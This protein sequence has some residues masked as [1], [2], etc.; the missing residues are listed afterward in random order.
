[1]ISNTKEEILSLLASL[2]DDTVAITIH[3]VS[4][5][6]YE[7][8]YDD[9]M[10]CSKEHDNDK[11]FCSSKETYEINN[12]DITD[13]IDFDVNTVNTKCYVMAQVFDDSEQELI[14]DQEDINVMFPSLIDNQDVSNAFQPS[15]PSTIIALHILWFD[16][17]FSISNNNKSNESDKDD[18]SMFDTSDEDY[19]L[20]DDDSNKSNEVRWSTSSKVNNDKRTIIYISSNK[21]NEDYDQYIKILPSNKS[22]DRQNINYIVLDNNNNNMVI[23]LRQDAPTVC[24]II[25][26]DINSYANDNI[27]WY[28]Q[29]FTIYEK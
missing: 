28:I 12:K 26:S 21:S 16:H 20:H 8:L 4:Y 22:S 13:K 27:L 17:G 3:E 9:I 19:D 7:S 10:E 15:N 5:P 23:K 2:P 14:Q 29:W 24:G 1:M 6:N 25:N 11:N 18:C